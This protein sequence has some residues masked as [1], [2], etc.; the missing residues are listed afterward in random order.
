MLTWNNKYSVDI[1]C[2]DGD[3]VILISLLNQ[4]H[5]NLAEEKSEEAL[6]PVLAALLNYA[7]YHFGYEEQI[8]ERYQFP[9]FDSHRAAHD[10][11]RDKVKALI[12]E[13]ENTEQKARRVRTLLSSWL[14]DHIVRV[15]GVLSTWLI[16]NGIRDPDLNHP[17][18]GSVET[19]PPV[20]P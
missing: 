14:F 15:D 6:G 16:A 11:F 20:L 4:L 5:I 7:S 13:T 9:G 12:A 19:A 10:R 18:S 2:L 17:I 3:H 1:P 8:M